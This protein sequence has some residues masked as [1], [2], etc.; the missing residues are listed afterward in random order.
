[1]VTACCGRSCG[2]RLSHIRHARTDTHRTRTYIAYSRTKL[3]SHEEAFQVAVQT[4]ALHHRLLPCARGTLSQA[5][6]DRQ[7]TELHAR[8]TADM[9]TRRYVCTHADTCAHIHVHTY[10]HARALLPCLLFLF[11]P[12]SPPPAQ[13]PAPTQSLP[14]SEAGSR[15]SRDDLGTQP[16]HAHCTHSR[17]TL[18]DTESLPQTHPALEEPRDRHAH[19]APPLARAPAH[20]RSSIAAKSALLRV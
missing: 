20:T 5:Q 9:H 18:H 12:P 2:R 4:E 1:M 6:R 3:S 11:S 19:H 10:T 16:Q 7:A 17:T 8:A 15:H 14:P 13:P